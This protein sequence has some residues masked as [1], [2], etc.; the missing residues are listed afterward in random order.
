MVTGITLCSCP[1]LRASV[2]NY[3]ECNSSYITAE[4][5]VKLY[6]N[7]WSNA[8]LYMEAGID[9][10]LRLSYNHALRQVANL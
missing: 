3:C 5:L 7:S 4:N 1:P 10:T 2:R 6:L 9:I 8:L